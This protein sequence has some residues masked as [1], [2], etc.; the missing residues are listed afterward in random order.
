MLTPRTADGTGTFLHGDRT[1]VVV[2][3][4]NIGF[5][6][7]KVFIAPSHCRS[8]AF[9]WPFLGL[10]I[11]AWNH[12]PSLTFDCFLLPFDCLSLSFYCFL[13]P[14]DCLSLSFTWPLSHCL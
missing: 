12:C 13:L 7:D 9:D 14:F 8:L 5:A 11:T 2:E 3:Q 4:G 6:L 1:L 10:Y